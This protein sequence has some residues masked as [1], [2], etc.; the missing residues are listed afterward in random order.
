MLLVMADWKV[1]SHHSPEADRDPGTLHGFGLTGVDYCLLSDHGCEY[2][3]VSTDSSFACQCPEGHVLHS[4]GKTCAS[5]SP[6]IWDPGTGLS[7]SPCGCPGLLACACAQVS[8]LRPH[9]ALVMCM[10]TSQSHWGLCPKLP[11]HA[12]ENG[13]A[14]SASPPLGNRPSFLACCCGLSCA[15]LILLFKFGC[16]H[17]PFGTWKFSKVIMLVERISAFLRGVG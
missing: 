3:C 16:H 9:W 10:P 7:M 4:D 1:T 6:H 5:E 11:S 17:D 15:L 14:I 8:S 13:F 12:P 2:S